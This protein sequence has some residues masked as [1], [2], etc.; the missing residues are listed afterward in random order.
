MFILPFLDVRLHYQ[1]PTIPRHCVAAFAILK[2]EWV[3]RAMNSVP[4]G[5]K[6]LNFDDLSCSLKPLFSCRRSLLS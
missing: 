6:A 4:N 1:S 3:I 5:N 2:V